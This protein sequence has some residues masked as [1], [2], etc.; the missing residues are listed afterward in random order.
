M[1]PMKIPGEINI[2]KEDQPVEEELK[3][4]DIMSQ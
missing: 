4:E 3:E 1:G 2:Q